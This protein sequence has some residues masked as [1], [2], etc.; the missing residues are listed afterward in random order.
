MYGVIYKITNLINS[1]I[2]I[3]QTIKKMQIRWKEHQSAAKRGINTYFHKAIRKYGIENFIIEQIAEA[4]SKQE[5]DELEIKYIQEYDCL[6]P[7]G[8]NIN[9]GG[10]NT[11]N[12]ANNPNIDIIKQHISEGRKR[13]F[14]NWTEEERKNFSE[15]CRQRTLDPNG[16]YQSQE[17]K[18]KMRIACTGKKCSEE[19]K[20]KIKARTTGREVNKELRSKWCNDRKGKYS[21]NHWWN[22][23]IDQKFCK[24]CPGENWVQGRLNPHWNQ[25]KYKVY[26]VELDKKFNSYLEAAKFICKILEDLELTQRRISR[27]CNGKYTEAFGYHWKLIKDK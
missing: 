13:Y 6:A 7:N 4:N 3:G 9:K 24:E 5:L 17:Y 1:K 10:G 14:A 21:G 18:E 25:R 8:Y 22:N 11:D 2:Y 27:A 12:F 23:G 19:T 15:Q 20:K 16:P 26:C